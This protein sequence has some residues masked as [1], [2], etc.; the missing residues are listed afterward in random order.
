MKGYDNSPGKPTVLS[1]VAASLIY[2][3]NLKLLDNPLFIIFVE[4]KFF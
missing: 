1:S 2:A 3:D 4:E